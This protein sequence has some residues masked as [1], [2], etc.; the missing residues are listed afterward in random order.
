MNDLKFDILM[1]TYKGAKVV[2]DTLR[3]ILSQSFTNYEIIICDDCSPDD[4]EEVVKSLADPRIKFYKGE[5]NLGYPG[6][7]ERCRQKATGDILYLMGQDDILGKDALLN[8]YKAFKMSDDIGAVV[9]PYF[10]FDKDI[11]TPVRAKNQLN[12]ERDEVVTINDSLK[13]VIAVFS[14]VDQLSGLALR[15][16]Y[17]D[18]PF[19]PDIFP[20]HIYPLASIFKK[21]P[22]VF[23]KD[24][25]LAVQIAT[26]H[27][28][29]ISA[30]YARSPL[31]SWVDMFNTVFSGYKFKKF[32]EAIIKNFVALN[33]IGLI[34]IRNH[35]RYRYFLREVF[36]L[37]KYRWENIYH[38]FF[39]F[40]SVG[41]A[42]MP[43][44]LL[45][46]LVDWYKNSVSSKFKKL[47]EIRFEYVLAG[48]K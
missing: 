24:Y 28:R 40:F 2:G 19:H 18:I 1:P 46:P 39:W 21:H 48:E 6:N 43:P 44:V 36:L 32:R 22:V 34:Q 25:N 47:K 7:L 4:T 17:M 38:P 37:L 8:T 13:R 5:K 33:H 27:S 29:G 30:V 16:K 10:W 41:C 12:P 9:R 35:G 31:Q 42:V 45:R 15:R 26:S 3:S 20:C 14:T 23:L 11:H